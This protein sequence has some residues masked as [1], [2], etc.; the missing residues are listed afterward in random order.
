MRILVVALV[1]SVHVARWLAAIADQGWDVHLFPSIDGGTAY[2]DLAGVTVH[3]SIYVPADN[4]RHN[5]R[6]RGLPVP[7]PAFATRVAQQIGLLGR[8]FLRKVWPNYRIWQLQR[9][10]RTLQPNLIHAIELQ[11]A[12]YLVLEAR[13]FFD[14]AFPRV[15]ITNY[16]SDIYLYG[17]L[18]EH[19]EKLEA[20]LALADF[21][22]CEC[23]RDVALAR[24]L[25]F[26][27]EVM[28]VM[29]NS[30]GFDLGHYTAFRQPGPV[31]ARQTIFLK[32][33][34]HWAGRAL[35]GLRAIALC[36]DVLAGYRVVVMPA[37]EDVGLAAAVI[38]YETGLQIDVLKQSPHDEVLRQL[39]MSRISIGL[40]ISDGIS[41]TF[42]EALVMGAFPIQSCTACADESRRPI[43]G[44]RCSSK[45]SRAC[46]TR[47][48]PISNTSSSMTAPRTRPQPSW[49]VTRDASAGNPIP[50][51][52]RP[53]P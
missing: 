39:G 35:F 3:H 32:G 1:D 2:P 46:S 6:L 23:E 13:Q 50:T 9:L 27:G 52:A 44:L 19:R 16:G 49:P 40:S 7:L 51:W 45:P 24:D 47:D 34:Q 10:I 37:G 15:M 29:P 53:A 25:G 18:A 21:Y 26:T 12:G 14:G 11:Y 22:T 48:T 5:V 43:T 4:P 41:H 17:R 31:S 28:P 42:L 33:Y 8:K 20:L 30:G 38:A 36:A